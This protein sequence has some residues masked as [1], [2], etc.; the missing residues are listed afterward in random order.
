MKQ[1]EHCFNEQVFM[2]EFSAAS[3]DMTIMTLSRF[4]IT[5]QYVHLTVIKKLTNIISISSKLQ[6]SA[7]KQQNKYKCLNTIHSDY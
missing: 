4:N 3:E 6:L 7:G 1:L 2:L 5:V